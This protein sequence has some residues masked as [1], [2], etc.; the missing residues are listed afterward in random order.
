[1]HLL[2]NPSHMFCGIWSNTKIGSLKNKM[3]PLGLFPQCFGRC[4]WISECKLFGMSPKIVLQY[5]LVF[6]YYWQSSDNYKLLHPLGLSVDVSSS[7]WCYDNKPCHAKY[8]L[9]AWHT[10]SKALQRLFS[11][12]DRVT[13][14]L[15][16]ILAVTIFMTS[17]F[18]Q[19]WCSSTSNT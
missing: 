9:T 4:L 15:I 8:S 6:F 16:A 10:T 1:M 7:V 3:G 17:A 13:C 5:H 11:H 2:F 19:Y 18:E 12:I 14:H